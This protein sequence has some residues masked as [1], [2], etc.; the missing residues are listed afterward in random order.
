MSRSKH[1]HWARARAEDTRR[2]S[3]DALTKGPR[4]GGYT[5]SAVYYPDEP[6][7]RGHEAWLHSFTGY[8][9][10]RKARAHRKILKRLGRR[11][12]RQRMKR[13]D[14]EV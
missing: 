2:S 10:D 3:R 5:V 11:A 6:T 12:E 1:R 4:A 14:R 8:R 13:E 7:G 9:K